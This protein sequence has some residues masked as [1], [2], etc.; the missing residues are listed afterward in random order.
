MD[1]SS[2][3]VGLGVALTAAGIAA[4]VF[5]FFFLFYLTPQSDF[6]DKNR[7]GCIFKGRNWLEGIED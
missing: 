2:G 3:L 4:D 7:N 5:F 6:V 1:G